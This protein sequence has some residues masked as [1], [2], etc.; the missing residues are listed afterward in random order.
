M[1]FLHFINLVD[2][3]LVDFKAKWT[4]AMAKLVLMNS[5]LEC[6]IS[7]FVVH[8][9]KR[10]TCINQATQEY[11]I[12]PIFFFSKG[13]KIQ[14]TIGRLR[15]ISHISNHYLSITEYKPECLDLFSLLL[16]LFTKWSDFK[17]L[18]LCLDSMETHISLKHLHFCNQCPILPKWPLT[19]SALLQAVASYCRYFN[20]RISRIRI[21]RL[22]LT[23]LSSWMGNS[24][25]PLDKTD[26]NN[27]DVHS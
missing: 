27:M 11:L 8:F 7:E 20:C 17:F 14:I 9:K 4:H 21:Y 18:N 25:L 26:K 1:L 10:S 6:T 13:Q 2:F 15:N 3:N 12:S 24:K 5:W 19:L 16:Q 22:G 23:S